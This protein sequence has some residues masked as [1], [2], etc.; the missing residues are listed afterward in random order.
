MAGGLSPLCCRINPDPGAAVCLIKSAVL[1]GLRLHQPSGGRSPSPRGAFLFG[2]RK[3]WVTQVS[4]LVFQY[5]AGLGVELHVP[6][7]ASVSVRSTS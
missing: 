6:F 7:L 3:C 1:L 4:L 5:F 2:T